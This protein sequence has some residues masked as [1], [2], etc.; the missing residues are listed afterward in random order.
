[1]ASTSFSWSFKCCRRRSISSLCSASSWSIID[2]CCCSRACWNSVPALLR[3]R[4][5]CWGARC[6]SLPLLWKWASGVCCPPAAAAPPSSSWPSVNVKKLSWLLAAE[7]LGDGVASC[8]GFVISAMICNDIINQTGSFLLCTCWSTGHYCIK[9][10]PW[11]EPKIYHTAIHGRNFSAH[12][13]QKL[14]QILQHKP[15]LS[16]L[17]VVMGCYLLLIIFTFERLLHTVR[18]HT[19]L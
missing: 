3:F 9:A 14:V 18:Q 13:C 6:S 19:L 5:S 2:C 15:P 11:R 16:I 4:E 8:H 7:E 12:Y 17:L 1:M 10:Q